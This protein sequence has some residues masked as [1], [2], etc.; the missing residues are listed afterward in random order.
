MFPVAHLRAL[1]PGQ[2]QPQRL[3]Q[4][5]DLRGERV[6]DL[7]GLVT[8]GQVQQHRVAGL[9]FDQGADRGLVL[10]ADD[11]VAFLISWPG[12]VFDL[13]RT[14]T[15]IDHVRDAV[16]ALAALATRVPQRPPGA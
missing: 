8:T 6:A 12:P 9:A 3:G 4:R 2:R 5:L 7:L 10:L 15:D 11:Q 1:V 16:L 14:L 13:S